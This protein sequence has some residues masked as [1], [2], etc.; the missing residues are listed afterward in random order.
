MGQT[1]KLVILLAAFHHRAL[2]IA[3]HG[4]LGSVAAE[5]LLHGTF[6]PPRCE[7]GSAAFEAAVDVLSDAQVHPLGKTVVYHMS[8]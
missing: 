2:S 3:R 4:L 7:I 5:W 1:K 6:L 8:S